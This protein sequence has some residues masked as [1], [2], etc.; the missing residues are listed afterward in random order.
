MYL[1]KACGIWFHRNGCSI[2][3]SSIHM[4]LNSKYEKHQREQLLV[5]FLV[6]TSCILFRILCDVGLFSSHAIVTVLIVLQTGVSCNYGFATQAIIESF[7]LYVN[8]GAISLTV[9]SFRLSYFTNY[10]FVMFL[11]YFFC[12]IRWIILSDRLSSV[13]TLVHVMCFVPWFKRKKMF[14]MSVLVTSFIFP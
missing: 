1:I 6:R 3:E 14:Q 12:I 11:Y 13:V 8:N 2:G 9:R 10:C 5:I 7:V 4:V